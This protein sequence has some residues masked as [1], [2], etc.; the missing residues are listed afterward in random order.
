MEDRTG[1]DLHHNPRH[2][3]ERE[4][5]QGEVTLASIGYFVFRQIR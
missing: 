2:L 5:L 4:E 1:N 3:E